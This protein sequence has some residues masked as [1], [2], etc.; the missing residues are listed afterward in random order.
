MGDRQNQ[1]PSR[2][3]PL[4]R[5]AA[6]IRRPPTVFMRARNPW[7]RLRLI[8]LGWYVRFIGSAL[9]LV[10]AATVLL[11]RAANLLP[12]VEGCQYIIVIS[13][14]RHVSQQDQ[15]VAGRGGFFDRRHIGKQLKQRRFL[16]RR[17]AQ[18]L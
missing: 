6:S 10:S 7:L 16:E 11:Q 13:S 3:R 12:R 8:T 5:R 1:T 17:H 4:A 15:L 18:D 2:R 14:V 9:L